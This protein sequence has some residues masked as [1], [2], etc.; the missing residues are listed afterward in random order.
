MTL[1]NSQSRIALLRAA[2]NSPR[3]SVVALVAWMS[4]AGGTIAGAVAALLAAAVLTP[5]EPVSGTQIALMALSYGV[6]AGVAGAI[7]GTIVGFGALRRVPLG[8]LILCTNLGL[9]LGLAAGWLGGPWA[10]HHFGTLGLIGFT[11]G[12]VVAHLLTRRT[13][14]SPSLAPN[15]S[16]LL[17]GDFEAGAMR[18]HDLPASPTEQPPRMP[19][20]G[21]RVMREE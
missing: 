19:A 17:R 18:Q 10:W 20:R 14:P 6:V 8:R 12:A 7:L 4:A 11:A 5:S 9:A 13:P 15:D 3:A 21:D 1:S 2:I 16:R